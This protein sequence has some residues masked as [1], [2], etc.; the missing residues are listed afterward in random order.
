MK[1]AGD[2]PS[3]RQGHSAVLLEGKYYVVYGGWCWILHIE[4]CTCCGFVR[5]ET[6]L[7]I[8]RSNHEEERGHGN[9]EGTSATRLRGAETGS[10]AILGGCEFPGRKC[11]EGEHVLSVLGYDGKDWT[12]RNLERRSKYEDLT[13][14][15]HTATVLPGRLNTTIIVFGGC[16]L[17]RVCYNDV[18]RLVVSSVEDAVPE[19]KDEE[20]EGGRGRGLRR[21]WR[22]CRR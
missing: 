15:G 6:E 21:G 4:R 16:Q 22:N 8:V 12:W 1:I 13:R 17:D 10:L 9:W 18:I 20:V 19:I 3:P 14:F 7:K 5:D 11:K 2:A